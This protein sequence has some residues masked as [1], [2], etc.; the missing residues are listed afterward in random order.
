MGSAWRTPYTTWLGE[1]GEK[2]GVP[3]GPEKIAFLVGELGG[4]LGAADDA[5]E[6]RLLG[7]G[8]LGVGGIE[9][10]SGGLFQLEGEK[11]ANTK[12]TVN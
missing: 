8:G 10:A 11:E 3:V 7:V 2:K 5:E 6:K 4:K 12:E 9:L 1:K